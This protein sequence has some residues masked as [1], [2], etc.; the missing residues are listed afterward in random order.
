MSGREAVAT[1]VLAAHG[2]VDGVA[3]ALGRGA[4]PRRVAA[5]PETVERGLAQ[6]VLTLIELLR[7]LMERQALRRMEQ[8]T[9]DDEQI[10]RLGETFMKLADRMDELK[11]EFGLRDEDLNLDLGP[12]G[13]LL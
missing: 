13:R 10:E 3:R 8:G 1:K 11:A 2:D 6:L 7:Q 9:L 12:L 4:L 5:D